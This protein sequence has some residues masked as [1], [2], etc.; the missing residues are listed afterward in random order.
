MLSSRDE[1]CV[2]RAMLMCEVYVRLTLCKLGHLVISSD[3]LTRV[4]ASKSIQECSSVTVCS[5]SWFPHSQQTTHQCWYCTSG[6]RWWLSWQKS[7]DFLHPLKM[8]YCQFWPGRCAYTL[9]CWLRCLNTPFWFVCDAVLQCSYTR[10]T[11]ST[12]LCNESPVAVSP[13][14]PCLTYATDMYST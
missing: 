12:L 11:V 10:V 8:L 9:H 5:K 14:Y 7:H 13:I 1:T 3:Q 6:H 4:L 2:T